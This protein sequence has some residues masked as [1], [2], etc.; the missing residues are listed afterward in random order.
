MPKLV[1][2]NPVTKQV[3]TYLIVCDSDIPE[4]LGEDIDTVAISL[5]SLKKAAKSIQHCPVGGMRSYQQLM[6]DLSIAQDSIQVLEINLRDG[7]QDYEMFAKHLSFLR[8]K[9]DKMS[10]RERW[11]YL[12]RGYREYLREIEMGFYDEQRNRQ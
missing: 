11:R 2:E 7:N 12:F 8:N 10:F 9:F 3:N 5:S 4:L 1:V 6:E